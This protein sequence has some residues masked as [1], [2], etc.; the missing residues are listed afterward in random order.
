MNIVWLKK[1]LRLSDHAP[2]YHAIADGRPFALVF[3]F[4]PSISQTPSFDVRHWWF[5]YNALEE[6]NAAL[7][8]FNLPVHIFHNEV[9]AVFSA[10]HGNAP[11]KDNNNGIEVIF[12]HQET[13]I[14]ATYTRDKQMAQFCKDNGIIW[15]EYADNGI[16]RGLKSLEGW[17]KMWGSAMKQP[18]FNVNLRQAK[19]AVPDKQWLQ[20]EK[21]IS[22]LPPEIKQTAPPFLPDWAYQK[23]GEQQAQQLL[24]SFIET[25]SR[26][27]LTQLHQAEPTLHSS[28]RLSAYLTYGNIS[29]RQI[30]QTLRRYPSNRNLSAFKSRLIKRFQYIQQFEMEERIEFE[31]LNFAFN[32]IRIKNDPNH[33]EAWAA[34][35]TGYPLVDAAMRC[36]RSTG[37]LSFDLRAYL[38]SFLTHHLWLDWRKGG[39][40]YLAR[41][42]MDFEPGLH[43][44]QIQIQAGCTGFH[45]IHISNL[46]KQS[47]EQDPQAIFIKQW[48]PELSRVPPELCH[49]PWQMSDL[50]QQ[51]YQCKP[52]KDYPKPII[53]HE[54][55][56]IFAYNELTRVK[57]SI[58]GRQEAA[59][60]RDRYMLD[61]R[62]KTN[63]DE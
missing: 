56:Q 32:G 27:Y 53:D 10:I 60:L 39:A 55:T 25:R 45:P 3:C 51:W 14:A 21:R 42:F 9:I 37:Y 63:K 52:G 26:Q 20:T 24:L 1:D 43:Y 59:R 8:P 38:V 57:N 62:T 29:A 19:S 34:G 47:R 7:Y 12:S 6:M 48:L 44:T 49:T 35:Q 31:N 61:H 41:Q 22:T 15:R 54:R 28:S 2:L 33:Y 4:E 30:F 50:E 11:D 58:L 18:L 46:V 23:F 16:V 17:G 5:M 36:V 40:N 13:G